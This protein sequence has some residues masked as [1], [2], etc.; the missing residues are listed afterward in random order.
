MTCPDCGGAP[1]ETTDSEDRERMYMCQECGH[2]GPQREF[3]EPQEPDPPR[4]WRARIADFL[5]RIAD[6]IYI[7]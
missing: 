5:M 7:R 2:Q 4:T 1:V 6:W 3:P